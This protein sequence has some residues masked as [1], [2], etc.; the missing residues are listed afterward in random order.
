VTDLQP[1]AG[2]PL[3][4]LT[5]TQTKVA[6][7]SPLRGMK[8]TGISLA[9]TNVSDL[10]PLAGM[11]LRDVNLVNCGKV[12]TLAPLA[13]LPLEILRMD[14]MTVTDIS[15]LRG[16][17][18]RLVSFT[19]YRSYFHD[20][21]ALAGSPTLEKVNLPWDISDISFLATLPKLQKVGF[22]RQGDPRRCFHPQNF[23]RSTDRTCRRSKPPAP[24]SPPPV[25]GIGP[26]AG[27]KPIPTTASCSISWG[28][29]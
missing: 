12:R 27:S 19:N 15:P 9:S 6:D 10:S 14:L 20:F 29:A 1:L 8:L 11:P 13:G 25:C 18:L 4:W 26:S 16:L 2:L 28:L 3:T 23:A 17:P 24:R 7:L 21:S 22:I 5:L